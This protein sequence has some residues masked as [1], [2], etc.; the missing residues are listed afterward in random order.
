M[1]CIYSLAYAMKR[2]SLLDAIG[3][4]NK[5]RYLQTVFESPFGASIQEPRAGHLASDLAHVK[6]AMP[7]KVVQLDELI[8]FSRAAQEA[9]VEKTMRLLAWLDRSMGSN[10]H[11]IPRHICMES[12]AVFLTLH[13][14]PRT[15]TLPLHTSTSP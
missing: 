12:G 6:T 15:Q 1:L 4:V 3:P 5:L 10:L 11:T 9:S 7:F 13:L 14:I 8:R 2:Q